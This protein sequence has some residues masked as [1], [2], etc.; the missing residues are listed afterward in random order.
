MASNYKKLTVR[1]IV[2]AVLCDKESFPKGIDTPVFSG[3]FEGNVT[4][5]KH[6][7][8]SIDPDEVIDEPSVFLGYEMHE[9]VYEW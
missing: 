3:D 8:Q 7:I 2:N 5:G 9:S 1:D 6:E 4:H